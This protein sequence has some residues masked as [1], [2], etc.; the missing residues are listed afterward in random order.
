MEQNDGLAVTA[1]GSLPSGGPDDAELADAVRA[2]QTSAYAE[3]YVRHLASARNLARQLTRSPAEADDL[4]SVAFAKVLE[5][6]CGG[7]GPAG[8]GFRAYL[9]TTLRYT[10]YDQ[11]RRE[12]KL[13]LTDD[14]TTAGGVDPAAVSEPFRDTVSARAECSLVAR[15][16]AALPER[17]QAVLRHTAVEG[18]SP[19]A[20]APL[21]G[22][23]PN[24]A[25]ALAY[26]AREGL[27]QAYLQAH[28]GDAAA[29]RCQAT[30]ERLGAWTRGGLSTRDTAL[31]R[32]HLAECGR[33]P[34]LA[35]DLAEL[36][37]AA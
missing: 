36:N 16:F 23:T 15:A 35:A 1:A 9:L 26:R 3:L 25:A 21:L 34:V 31:V 14:V 19:A 17:W 7:R 29:A 28:L 27:R 24:G 37:P 30:V 2:G 6:L 11:F 18:L 22:L 33:C 8:V 20:A 5:T 12:R 10:A 32:S 4:V 13:V